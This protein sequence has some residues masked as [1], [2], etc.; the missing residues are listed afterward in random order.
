MPALAA[1][2][3]VARHGTH[4]TPTLLSYPVAA[5]AKG[6]TGSALVLNAS[7]LV[8][9][10]TTATGLTALGVSTRDF[11]NTAGSASA[12]VVEAEAGIFAMENSAAADQILQADVGKDCFFVDDQTVAKTNGGS[13]RSVAGK[14]VRLEEGKVWV[15]IS[16]F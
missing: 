5:G 6:F 15:R 11:D 1:G 16:A 14:V 7:G 8:A 10:A 12:F 9:Q 13:T 3:A 4:P 2:K